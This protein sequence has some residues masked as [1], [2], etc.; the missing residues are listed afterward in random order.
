MSSRGK[1]V[2][3]SSSLREI[4]RGIELEED[5]PMPLPGIGPADWPQ[6]QTTPGTALVCRNEGLPVSR[7]RE[8]EAAGLPGAAGG[9]QP[10]GTSLRRVGFGIGTTALLSSLLLCGSLF[11]MPTQSGPDLADADLDGFRRATSSSQLSFASEAF[12]A[13][14]EPDPAGTVDPH[15]GVQAF[16]AIGHKAILSDADTVPNMPIVVTL[17]AKE[18]VAAH[19]GETVDL[20]FDIKGADALA[21]GTTLVIL[22]VPENAAL[23]AAEPQGDGVWTLPVNQAADVKLTA[24]TLP[25]ST[26]ENLVAELRSPEGEVLA[27]ATT[28]LLA[29]EPSVSGPAV[30]GSRPGKSRVAGSKPRPIAATVSEWAVVPK[31]PKAAAE[32]PA[33]TIAQSD[34]PPRE[35]PEWL[36]DGGRSALGGPR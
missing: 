21:A 19:P 2:T 4:L 28:R 36:A 27:R 11:V 10:S 29:Q 8:A 16:A 7:V 30:A 33:E 1:H 6:T 13:A 12:A 26:I 9:E 14:A 25:A 20:A 22:G 3:A 17:A 31:S 35:T 23:S 15:T 24:Y 5:D 34:E 18:S 32:Q